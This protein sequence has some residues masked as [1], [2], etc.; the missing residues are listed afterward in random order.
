ME[1]SNN[2]TFDIDR[3]EEILRIMKKKEIPRAQA[4]AQ[5]TSHKYYLNKKDKA[6]QYYI[7]NKERLNEYRTKL[8]R[9]RKA[10]KGFIPK[11]EKTKK[12]KQP[13]GPKGRPRKNVSEIENE[14][15]RLNEINNIQKEEYYKQ[16]KDIIVD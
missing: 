16:K 7:D 12:P 1:N 10:Q 8:Y 15:L 13:K 3:E 9:L 11:E 5:Y 2:I 14:I 4:L 6:K